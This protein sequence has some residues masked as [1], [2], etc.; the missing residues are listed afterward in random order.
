MGTL[1]MGKSVATE[2]Q[3]KRYLKKVNPRV[4]EAVLN[5]L[6]YYLKEGEIEGVRGDI[7]AAQSFLETGNFTFTGS[8]V[9]LEQNNFA[10]MGVIQNGMQGESWDTPQMGIRAQIQHLKAYACIESLNT[11]CVDGRFKYVQRGCAKYVEWLGIQENPIRAG[12]AS[13]KD[14]GNKILNIL[15]AIT[16]GKTEE[17]RDKMRINIHAGHNFH[18]PGA[19][20]IFSETEED[21][22]VKNLVIE[23]LR[24]GGHTVYDCTDE[25][26][27]TEKA[28]LANI[29]NKCNQHTVDYDVSIHFNSF[30]Q[31]AYGVEVL[32][33][34]FGSAAE[35]AA[36]RVAD[37]IGELGYTKRAGGVKERPGLY[38]L[39]HTSNPAMLVE[40]C[41]CDSEKDAAM[42]SAES[43]ANAIVAGITGTSMAG[44][45][46]VTVAEGWL[47]KGNTGNEVVEWQKTLNVFGSEVNT[48]GDFGPD[49][50]MQTIRVQRLVG[51]NPDGCVGE[52]TKNAVSA[53]LKADN[54]IQV[55]DGRW[56]YRHANGGYKKNAWEKIGGV[57]FHFDA[58]GWMQTGWVKDNEKWYYLKANGAMVSDSLVRTGGK[59]YYVDKSGKM[60]YTDASGALK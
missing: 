56:W 29:V 14:Y 38:V 24:A 23:K 5:M 20:G 41:F 42:Y 17:S 28:N 11:P 13:G 26:G 37:R 49:T 36:Q 1:I 39:K 18:T 31:Q 22:K 55:R 4:P 21:R 3:L 58:A 16:E 47:S 19:S 34:A 32:V 57:W 40:C 53:Y 51:V 44:N 8:A 33:Y 54:W 46:P 2:E 27:M 6:H 35:S 60:C 15:S 7:A 25:E 10:G 48:D 52:K 30:N 59:V 45:K 50:E 12:W 9:K 43:M